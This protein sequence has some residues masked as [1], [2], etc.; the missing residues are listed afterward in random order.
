MTPVR[1]VLYVTWT[2]P[3]T[4]E[5]F[6]VNEVNALRQRSVDVRVMTFG[7]GD[8]QLEPPEELRT[9]RLSAADGWPRVRDLRRAADHP[10]DEVRSRV[11]AAAASR[12]G[13]ARLDGWRPDVVHV[14]F[15]D[16]PALLGLHVGTRLGVPVTL[17]AHAVDYLEHVPPAIFA[18]RYLA[19]AQVY[20]ISRAAVA[21]ITDRVQRFHREARPPQLVRASVQ[22]NPDSA[23]VPPSP[24]VVSVARLVPK[25]GL[26]T[27]VRAF[28]L[29]AAEMPE[30]QLVIVGDGPGRA[31]LTALARATGFGD[32]VLFMGAQPA[33]VTHGVI[34]GAQAM[35]LPCRRVAGGDVD[36]IPVALMEAG[37]AGVPV[38]TTAVG[39]ILDLVEHER[40]GLI[41]PPDDPAAA[42]AALREIVTDTACRAALAAALRR[43]VETEFNADAQIDRLLHD[44]YRLGAAA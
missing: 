19:A 42:A 29:L 25:K 39:G 1:R 11:W 31:D 10:D 23:V 9:V 26:D 15:V 16:R 4:S 41:V 14:H 37:L 40:T 24:F 32:R 22:F 43:H 30:L 27:A 17:V 6:V 2:Y 28:A 18:D 13:V 8:Y 21:D 44:W 33:R 35:I 36:G 5:T 3:K 38:V 7:L 20:A 34:A 12:R